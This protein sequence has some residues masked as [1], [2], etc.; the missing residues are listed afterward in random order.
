MIRI[1]IIK[2]LDKN[3][4]K[5]ACYEQFN[6]IQVGKRAARLHWLK[7]I[8]AATATLVVATRDQPVLFQ[9]KMTLLD[10]QT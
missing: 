10:F 8:Q 1:R 2:G 4:K 6:G 3:G 5:C 9:R 7:R